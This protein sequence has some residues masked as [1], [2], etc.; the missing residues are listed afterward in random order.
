MITHS[1]PHFHPYRLRTLHQAECWC[2]ACLKISQRK[3]SDPTLPNTENY[4]HACAAWPW[5]PPIGSLNHMLA[6]PMKTSNQLMICL[7]QDNRRRLLEVSS[8]P[9]ILWLTTSSTVSLLNRYVLVLTLTCGRLEQTTE[10]MSPN[11]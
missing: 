3:N 5:F 6:L 9:D 2:M 7:K 10:K 4:N 11:I 1:I 8:V